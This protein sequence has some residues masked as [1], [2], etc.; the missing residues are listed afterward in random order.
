MDNWKLHVGV[1]SS[2]VL[3][4]TYIAVRQHHN[5]ILQQFS[6]SKQIPTSL[7][8]TQ[9]LLVSIAVPS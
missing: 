9:G 7:A 2:T 6:I 4:Y 1:Q 3:V 5:H 8:P